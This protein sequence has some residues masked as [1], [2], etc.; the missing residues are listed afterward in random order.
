MTVVLPLTGGY[1][2]LIDDEDAPRVLP[3][4]WSPSV[5]KNGD[6]YV[7]RNEY[8]SG[9]AHAVY[10]HRFLVEAGSGQLVD[11]KNLDPLDNRKAN[12]RLTDKA[13]NGTNRHKQARGSSRFK[14][15]HYYTARS[16][17]CAEVRYRGKRKHVGYFTDEREAARA[18]DA[19]A[20]EMQGAFA[21]TNAALGLL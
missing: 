18:Y 10:L 19:A 13:G 3:F 2:A 20:T 14:G 1:V 15:V 4:R 16:C 11:H 17:W 8:R 6:V 7:R 21:L 5:R 9:K 12:L